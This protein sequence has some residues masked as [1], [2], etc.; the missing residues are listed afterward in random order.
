MK[1][2]IVVDQIYSLSN[3]ENYNTILINSEYEIA[4]KYSELII[5]YYNIITKKNKLKNL[6][7]MNTILIRGLD[8]IT[9]IFLHLL[10]YTKNINLTCFHCQK[11]F[12]FYI[13][14]I[15]QIT[16]D[17]KLF[18]QLTP[19]DA[20]LYVYKK[21]I[22]EV[23][24][25]IK[26]IIGSKE[27]DKIFD[28]KDKNELVKN[29]INIIQTYIIKIVQTNYIEK[30]NIQIITIIIE[31]LKKINSPAMLNQLNNIIDKSFHKIENTN[32]FIDFNDMLIQLC[33]KNPT[34]LNK[35]QDKLN[36][37]NFVIKE[38]NVKTNAEFM[39]W[40]SSQ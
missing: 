37:Y 30:Q 10:Y 7:N 38:I 5:E 15:E 22:F 4:Q 39:K 33:I 40:L 26:K 29:Y 17:D 27:K 25:E 12:Y 24:D 9:N 20:S 28:Y 3:N 36:S 35:I 6:S 19:R 8:T 13:E 2:N 1:K 11:S 31:K 23:D 14:F 18:L 34:I 21:T 16:E 32:L